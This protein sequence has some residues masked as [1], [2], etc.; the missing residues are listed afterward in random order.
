MP[1]GE[2]TTPEIER[3]AAAIVDSALKVHRALGPGLLE[4]AYEACLA[5]EL[6]KRGFSVTRQ[7][8]LPIIYD[9]V[10]LDEAYRIDLVVNDLVIVEIKAVQQMKKLFARQTRTY[11]R[12]S[13][14]KLG[15]L[16]NFN[17][18]LIKNGIKRII[19]TT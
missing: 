9:D 8:F 11:L 5:H 15:L 13:G 1:F 16:I 6:R 7:V 4:S 19:H 10:E 18:N 17:V 2:T 12:L 14:R 3:I